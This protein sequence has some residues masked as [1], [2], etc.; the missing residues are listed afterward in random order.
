MQYYHLNNRLNNFE[1][2]LLQVEQYESII[3]YCSFETK[4]QIPKMGNK[5]VILTKSYDEPCIVYVSFKSV[6]R[7]L[8]V[9]INSIKILNIIYFKNFGKRRIFLNTCNEIKK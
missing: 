9:F 5:T 8:T 4:L 2:V 3:L 6:F 7:L 1:Q